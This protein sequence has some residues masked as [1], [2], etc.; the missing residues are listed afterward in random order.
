MHE[1]EVPDLVATEIRELHTEFADWL[2]GRSATLARVEA[3]LSEHFTMVS[4]SGDIVSRGEVMSGLLA[5][6]GSRPIEI[7]IDNPTVHWH[8]TDAVLATYEEWQDHGGSTTA[9]RST[10]LFTH[11]E[12]A[13]NG[14][15]WQ[16]VHETWMLPP[17]GDIST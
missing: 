10:A 9:R 1:A 11:D 17:P 3:A 7:R 6:R 14:L 12:D 13:P 2:S 8:L 16:H 15:L 4:P 5:A